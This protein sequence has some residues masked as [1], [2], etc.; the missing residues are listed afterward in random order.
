MLDTL[1]MFDKIHT[2]SVDTATISH[3]IAA[4]KGDEPWYLKLLEESIKNAIPVLS[5]IAGPLLGIWI[6]RRQ[7]IT[8]QYCTSVE[9][10][11]DLYKNLRREIL[12]LDISVRPVYQSEQTLEEV[13]ALMVSSIKEKRIIYEAIRKKWIGIV[14]DTVINKIEAVLKLINEISYEEAVADSKIKDMSIEDK[15]AAID[16][17]IANEYGTK[18]VNASNDVS[19]EIKTKIASL[20][21]SL[22]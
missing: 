3:I 16:D 4:I 14:D 6:Y 22:K 19:D 18:L 12:L 1:M 21:N 17:Y 10:E 20:R 15:V 5:G 8:D 11:I 13:L 2:V 7:K 9:K